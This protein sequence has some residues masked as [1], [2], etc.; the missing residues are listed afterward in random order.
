MPR[1][2]DGG[3]E[4]KHSWTKDAANNVPMS[5][6]RMDADFDDMAAAIDAIGKAHAPG[7]HVNRIE[8]HEH[9][10]GAATVA[11]IRRLEHIIAIKGHGTSAAP[12]TGV[13]PDV[14]HEIVTHRLSQLPPPA[15]TDAPT[16]AE[17]AN[18]IK[19]AVKAVPAATPLPAGVAGDHGLT[20]EDVTAVVNAGIAQAASEIEAKYTA[21]VAEMFQTLIL[22]ETITIAEGGHIDKRALIEARAAAVGQTY[23]QFVDATLADWEAMRHHAL[24]GQVN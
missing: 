4:R 1:K 20:I 6:E 11:D 7:A 2:P 9:K 17:V 23:D 3:F 18:L 5:P 12:T 14:V 13:T 24:G 15:A 19:A 22:V 8:F 10:Q 21:L 16:R